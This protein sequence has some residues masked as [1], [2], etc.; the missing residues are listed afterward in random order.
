MARHDGRPRNAAVAWGKLALVISINAVVMLA[1][2][3]AV[4]VYRPLGGG[5]DGTV[6]TVLV[7]AGIAELA[8]ALWFLQKANS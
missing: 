4:F 3:A 2:A 5:L 6:S 7:L 1:A 8:V